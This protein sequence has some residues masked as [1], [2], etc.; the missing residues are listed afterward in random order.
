[1][2]AH[3]AD[4]WTVLIVRGE[5]DVQ[6]APVVRE[7]ALGTRPLVIDLSGCTFLDAA[8]LRVL[9]EAAAARPPGMVRITRPDR[10]RGDLLRRC[11]LGH[12]L[13]G[14]ASAAELEPS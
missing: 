7:A 6:S 10:F 5:L 14:R 1:V 2:R 11:G 3:R 9:T 13:D 8:G 4:G 12:L